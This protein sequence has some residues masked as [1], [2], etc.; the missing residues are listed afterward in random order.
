[1]S[2]CNSSTS[3]LQ[4]NMFYN[5]TNTVTVATISVDNTKAYIVLINISYGW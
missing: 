5:S 3:V 4:E 1:M 2:A